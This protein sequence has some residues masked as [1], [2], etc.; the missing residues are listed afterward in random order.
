MWTIRL[1][2]EWSLPWL[3][4]RGI[5]NPRL[6]SDLLL[7]DALGVERLQLFLDPNRPVVGDE[8]ATFKRHLQRRARREPVAYILGRRGFWR[9]E[10]MV[11]S[12]VLVPRPETEL[13]VEAVL[14][15]FPP[16]I[17]RDPLSILELG[18]GSGAVLCSLLLEYADA[19]GV[20][21]DISAAAL[22]VAAE[23][24]RQLGT[25][26]RSTLLQGDLTEPL[27]DAHR[28][29]VIVANLPYIAT[30][31]LGQLEPE[32]GRWEPRQALDGGVD[33]LAVLRRVPGMVLP[34]LADGGLLAL[35]IGATQGDAVAAMLSAAGLQD[36][37][38]RLDYARL[39]RVVTGRLAG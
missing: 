32:V 20:G 21:V 9:Q 29:Q 24:A 15:T 35:E 33:G 22:A 25:L 37:A 38:L 8:L 10:F 34:F 30:D 4:Q 3:Q 13:L 19:L 6:D 5:D 1:L 26:A 23:N 11:T 17:Q 27:G 31:E 7:A 18:V 36:V 2:Q 14:E 39:P 16:D 12:A 28:F